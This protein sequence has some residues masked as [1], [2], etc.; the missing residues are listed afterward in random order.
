MAQYFIL[1]P[2]RLNKGT[3][4]V[5]FKLD[6]LAP[7]QLCLLNSLRDF[8]RQILGLGYF[9][10]IPNKVRILDYVTSGY[11]FFFLN[12]L[13]PGTLFSHF[14]VSTTRSIIDVL[15]LNIKL[16][17]LFAVIS[18]RVIYQSR[19]EQYG[20][21]F[22]SLPYVAELTPNCVGS[23]SFPLRQV[24]EHELMR[25]QNFPGIHLSYISCRARIPKLIIIQILSWLAIGMQVKIANFTCSQGPLSLIDQTGKK[26]GNNRTCMVNSEI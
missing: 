16:W 23:K 6:A 9:S 19:Q 11:H 2:L 14:S 25:L 15:Q 1:P 18:Q 5:V 20:V 21:L 4:F 12:P 7:Q 22:H 13:I 26:I 24:V 17:W 3:E 10:H 8:L